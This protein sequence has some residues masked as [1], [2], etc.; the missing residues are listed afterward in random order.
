MDLDSE[1]EKNKRLEKNNLDLK[2]EN[3]SLKRELSE[4][5]LDYEDI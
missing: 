1:R 4:L 2:A 3:E 5:K